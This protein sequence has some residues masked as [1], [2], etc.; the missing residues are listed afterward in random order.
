MVQAWGIGTN[1]IMEV[2][3]GETQFNM[4]NIEYYEEPLDFLHIR[5]N[6]L[7]KM[8]D[9]DFEIC[10]INCQDDLIGYYETGILDDDGN[11]LITDDNNMILY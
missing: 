7:R 8:N 4:K 11:N 9:F 5:H 1:G 10:G 6:F 2:H 3:T